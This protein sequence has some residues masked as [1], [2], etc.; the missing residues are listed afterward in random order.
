MDPYYTKKHASELQRMKE[1]V[2]KS[3]LLWEVGHGWVR[4]SEGLLHIQF[5]SLIILAKVKDAC[6]G[7]FTSAHC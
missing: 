7:E 1:A 4:E 6:T 3:G 5:P 2:M